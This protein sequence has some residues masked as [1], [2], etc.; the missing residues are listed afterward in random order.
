MDV[1]GRSPGLPVLSFGCALAALVALIAPGA[2]LHPAAAALLFAL[3]VASVASIGWRVAGHLL[4]DAPASV[5]LAAAVLGAEATAA[6]LVAVP[7]LLHAFHLPVVLAALAALCWFAHRQAPGP[8][9]TWHDLPFG[10][11]TRA[12]IVAT[13][14]ALGAVLALGARN[15]ILYTVQDADSMWYHLVMTGEWV[16]TGSLQPIDAIPVIG[17]AYPGFRQALLAWL[18]LPHGTEHLAL[19]G[20]LEFPLLALS[21]YTL[22]RE[23]GTARAVALA[24]GLGAATTPVALAALG[25]QGN[26]VCLAIHLLLSL[27]FLG[28][29][30]RGE[31]RGNTLFAGIALGALAATKYSGPGYAG[32]AVGVVVLQHGVRAA[33]QARS[34]S[35]LAVGA[36]LL[37]AGPWYLRNL[38]AFGNPLYPARVQL[39]RHVVFDGPL[40]KEWF[41]QSTVGFDVAPLVEHAG[42]FVAAH[43]WP[44]L[45]A[46]AAPVLAVVAAL[47]RA[48]PWRTALCLAALPILLFV[49]F[50]HHPFNHPLH[51]AEISQRYL[52]AWFAVSM[53]VVAAGLSATS[54]RWPWALVFL[55]AAFVSLRTITHW[56]VPAAVAVAAGTAACA[57]PAVR[58]FGDTACGWIRR[59]RGSTIAAF[60]LLA[61]AAFA[62]ERF[63]EREQ[64]DPAT[65]YHDSASE[66]GWGPVAAWVHRN[67]DDARV[68]LHG[69]IFLFPLLGEP[70][71]NR[72]FLADDLYLP[73]RKS[74]DQVA[75]WVRA[76]RLDWLVCCV[77]R[78][79]RVSTREFTFGE[80]IT[81]PLVA[82]FP[83]L[84]TVAFE[85]GGAAVLK[86][87]LDEGR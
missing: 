58:R 73:A 2:V 57:L 74:L 41:A 54:A 30:I 42:R 23:H 45:L 83:R 7:G 26:D 71:S 78:T 44:I 51:D 69:S 18:S 64:Y 22:A 14:L 33:W 55:A 86:V 79:G 25:T 77:P 48:A 17:I 39:G 28:R 75:E 38:I 66:R 84:F 43:G 53:A 72:L 3:L 37:L 87:H 16:R 46:A 24:C 82:R 65:G 68:G 76:N 6:S 21:V 31:G 60:A 10:R 32:L 67:V 62:I 85:R 50:L 52:I 19:L 49:A 13:L 4:P 34:A 12:G 1:T 20:I 61:V 59:F 81:A 9:S 56:A 29:W 36:A 63:R 5:V 8:R 35:W 47:R 27:V 70:F 11:P 40:G 15:Q 80:A